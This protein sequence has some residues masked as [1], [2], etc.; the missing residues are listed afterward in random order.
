MIWGGVV[1]LRAGAGAREAIRIWAGSRGL[2]RLLLVRTTPRPMS[3]GEAGSDE[4]DLVRGLEAEGLAVFP[5]EFSTGVC[6]S[7]VAE[8]VGAFHFDG[9]E[10]IVAIGGSA[11]IELA[12]LAALMVGQRRPLTELAGDTAAI[13]PDAVAPCIAVATDLDG[14]AALGGA[15]VVLDDRGCPFLLRDAALRPGAAAYCPAGADGSALVAAL[16]LDAGGEAR[17]AAEELM[18]GTGDTVGVALR[19]AAVLERQI[20]PGRVLSTYGE[21]VAGIPR[22]VFLAGVLETL[23]PDPLRTAI[24]AALDPS[25]AGRAAL[26][27]L[28]LDGL[29]HLDP[30]TLP[31]DISRTLTMLGREIPARRRRGGR[32][33]AAR[34]RGSE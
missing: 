21:V 20:G 1:P 16:A 28:Q 6:V 19:M 29:A 10:G 23:T 27:S 13:E 18:V 7:T 8:A 30:S 31:V 9:C 2:R 24:I 22:A 34:S 12:K 32:G 4:G 3:D 5:F 11:G 14:V 15:V 26:G 33:G 25:G 17:A